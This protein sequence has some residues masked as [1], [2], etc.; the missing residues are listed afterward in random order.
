M[1]ILG[2]KQNQK[3]ETKVKNAFD[4]LIR[5]GFNGRKKKTEK[6]ETE[7]PNTVGPLQKL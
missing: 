2:K 3:L 1:E 4:G 5:I 7:Y 6:K